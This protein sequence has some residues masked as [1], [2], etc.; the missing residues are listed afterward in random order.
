MRSN[1]NDTRRRQ[2]TGTANV[3]ERVLQ[4]FEDNPNT[5]THKILLSSL[6]SISQQC[7]RAGCVSLQSAKGAVTAAQRLSEACGICT[8]VHAPS[9]QASVFFTDEA[10]LSVENELSELTTILILRAWP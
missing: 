4:S 1:M 10:S 8:M 7:A 9:F 5:S 3:E 6:G 2:L